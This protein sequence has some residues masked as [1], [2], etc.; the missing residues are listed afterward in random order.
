MRHSH[1]VDLNREGVD[2]VTISTQLG[3]A[4]P[5]ITMLYLRSIAVEEKLAPI[6]ARRPPMM[7]LPLS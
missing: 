1:A 7:V 6:A 2:L 3:H 5:G 4:H